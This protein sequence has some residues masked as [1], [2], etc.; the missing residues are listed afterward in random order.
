MRL[1]RRSAV[2]LLGLTAAGCGGELSLSEMQAPVLEVR[3]YIYPSGA[4]PRLTLTLREGQGG[5]PTLSSKMRAYAN[6][7]EVPLLFAG[8]WLEG[9]PGI[10]SSLGGGS[11]CLESLFELEPGTEAFSL[12][13]DGLRIR[14]EEGEST[15]EAETPSYCSASRGFTP[16]APDVVLRPDAEVTLEWQPATDELNID[17]VWLEA[18]GQGERY[19]QVFSVARLDDGTLHVEGNRLRFRMPQVPERF[20]GPGE[21]AFS[22]GPDS[23]SGFSRFRVSRCEGFAECFFSCSNPQNPSVRVNVGP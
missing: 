10:P 8:R 5:C 22:L 19:R 9:G 11:T 7:V 6:D 3:S 2:W 16:L 13:G 20:H 14:L 18:D 17:E 4:P 23:Q 21:L 1:L 12:L 15:F